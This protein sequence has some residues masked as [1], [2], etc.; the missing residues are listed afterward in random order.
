MKTFIKISVNV[1]LWGTAFIVP[2][3]AQVTKISA[4]PAATTITNVDMIAFDQTNNGSGNFTTKTIS[5][6]NF[7]SSPSVTNA[8]ATVPLVNT[9]SNSVLTNILFTN[10]TISGKWKFTNN[11][12]TVLPPPPYTSNAAI[13]ITLNSTTISGPS[14]TW[15]NWLTGM[16]LYAGPGNANQYTFVRKLST[17]TAQVDPAGITTE[18]GQTGWAVSPISIHN[19]DFNNNDNGFG[20]DAGGNIILLDGS[21]SGSAPPLITMGSPQF[22]SQFW[23][24]VDL[25]GGGGL[26][27][28]FGPGA[29]SFGGNSAQQQTS[30]DGFKVSTAARYNSVAV[31]SNNALH[32]QYGITN[33]NDGSGG[34]TV[35]LDGP[36]NFRWGSQAV[37]SGQST[38]PGTMTI[39]SA[40]AVT[41][42]STTFTTT[43]LNCKVFFVGGQEYH[44]NQ[45]ASDTSMSVYEN[46]SAGAGSSYTI[47]PDALTTYANNNVNKNSG[48]HLGDSGELTILEGNP[49]INLSGGFGVNWYIVNHGGGFYIGSEVS[50]SGGLNTFPALFIDP[51]SQFNSIVVHSNN[52]VTLM[53][54]PTMHT[55]TGS[56][57]SVVTG[58]PGDTYFNQSGGSG[59]TFYVKESGTATTTGWVG[60]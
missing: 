18:V 1:L 7:E 35:E 53:N 25:L 34:G 11:P 46:I 9:A 48:T 38:G 13:N 56:P 33:A 36:N 5:L 3:A 55:G 6:I 60:K 47:E 27:A 45:I 40:G 41:G 19:P 51:N 23:G 59:T 49:Q 17:T 50:G 52:T 42:S 32:V 26:P 37:A 30:H 54:G 2:C 21:G 44:V 57:N 31:L 29:I 39:S 28:I 16:N 58:S 12:Q 10:Q 20:V 8:L 14:G 43:F 24:H 15:D 22:S 4:L